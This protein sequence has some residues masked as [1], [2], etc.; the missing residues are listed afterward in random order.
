MECIVGGFEPTSVSALA[1]VNDVRPILGP[2]DIA[3]D[4]R[5]LA[6]AAGHANDLT[7]TVFETPIGRAF[8]REVFFNGEQIRS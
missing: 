7:V 1:S 4:R 5:V 2:E 3:G 6:A 8:K